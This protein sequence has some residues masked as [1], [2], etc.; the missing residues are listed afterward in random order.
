MER[1][2]LHTW[3]F[4]KEFQVNVEMGLNPIKDIATVKFLFLV[5]WCYRSCQQLQIADQP[6]PVSQDCPCCSS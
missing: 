6:I 2:Y 1:A 4:T 5:I 3:N